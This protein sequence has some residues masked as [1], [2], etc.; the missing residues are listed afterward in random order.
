MKAAVGIPGEYR[1]ETVKA[2]VALSPYLSATEE[3]LIKF[4]KERMAN[5]RYPQQIEFMDKLPKTP[6]GKFLRRE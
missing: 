6:T 4:C 5:Y 2:F 3:E 1:G